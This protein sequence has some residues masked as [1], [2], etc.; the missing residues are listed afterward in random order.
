[1]SY[2][3]HYSYD[4][5]WIAISTKEH[6]RQRDLLAH[7]PHLAS[8]GTNS[9]PELRTYVNFLADA[10]VRVI[11]FRV[12]TVLQNLAK[13]E[14]ALQLL[15]K[16]SR[17]PLNASAKALSE[18]VTVVSLLMYNK[19]LSEAYLEVKSFSSFDMSSWL[20]RVH[21]KGN[22][23]EPCKDRVESHWSVAVEPDDRNTQNKSS[24]GGWQL[25]SFCCLCDKNG[26]SENSASRS[27][28]HMIRIWNKMEASGQNLVLKCTLIIGHSSL[29]PCA[30]QTIQESCRESTNFSHSHHQAAAKPHTMY[31]A[32][33]IAN[34]K[35]GL[36]Y[37]AS[38]GCI[39]GRGE[40]F[41]IL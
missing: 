15:P 8:N 5:E 12:I 16:S 19:Q 29:K 13:H 27:R 34:K 6:S 32:V 25:Q 10:A 31:G 35:N 24:L 14:F 40:H 4:V 18:T 30:G 3:V 17:E 2:D 39:R 37:W 33:G 11:P 28:Q 23:R 22:S 26:P 9:V 21:T 41:G 38:L 36:A 20:Q 1:M 7:L